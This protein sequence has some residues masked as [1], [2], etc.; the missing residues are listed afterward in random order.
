MKPVKNLPR[1][2]R[3]SS[4]GDGDTGHAGRA[5]IHYI[6]GNGG[7]ASYGSL[8]I[9]SGGA[10]LIDGQSTEDSAQGDAPGRSG[11]SPK[12]CRLEIFRHDHR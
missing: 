10:G 12:L 8:A 9:G 11:M 6:T 3:V 4:R 5:S 2:C 7:T 1:G